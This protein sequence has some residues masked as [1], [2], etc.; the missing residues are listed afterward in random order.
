MHET[1]AADAV[2]S[3]AS[4]YPHDGHVI[5]LLSEPCS[6]PLY[7]TIHNAKHV[8]GATA[9]LAGTRQLRY[10]R[11]HC[12]GEEPDNSTQYRF[13]RGLHSVDFLW[14]NCQILVLSEWS[15]QCQPCPIIILKALSPMPRLVA[16][17]CR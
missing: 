1:T 14:G 16:V 7:S 12:Y 8:R 5:P 9:R 6:L 11:H 15:S 17:E 3:T 13:W 4:A 10:R 2:A